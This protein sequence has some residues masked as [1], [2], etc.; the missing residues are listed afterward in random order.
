MVDHTSYFQHPTGVDIEEESALSAAERAEVAADAAEGYATQ[1]GGYATDANSWSD[2]SK[3]WAIQL[4]SMVDEGAGGVDYSSKHYA[5]VVAAGEASN[6]AASAAAAV[7]TLQEFERAY[8]GSK[9]AAPLVDN[10]H[11]SWTTRAAPYRRER[12]I[13]TRL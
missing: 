5:T 6:A 8:L 7:A 10:R 13:G 9:A 11:R 1:A 3:A 2:L 4:G 12:S